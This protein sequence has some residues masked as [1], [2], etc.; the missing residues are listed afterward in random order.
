MSCVYVGRANFILA[1]G[2][3]QPL[4]RVLLPLDSADVLLSYEPRPPGMQE[5]VNSKT[6][7]IPDSWQPRHR[8]CLQ[9]LIHLLITEPVLRRCAPLTLRGHLLS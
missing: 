9:V 6:P 7:W 2:H 4:R 8:H 3:N 1:L 5:L